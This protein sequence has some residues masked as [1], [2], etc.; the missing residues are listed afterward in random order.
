M[1]NDVFKFLKL[2]SDKSFHEERFMEGDVIVGG[3]LSYA[4]FADLPYY[5]HHDLVNGVTRM[6]AFYSEKNLDILTSNDLFPETAKIFFK[7]VLL[8][9]RYKNAEIGYFEDI[10]D[11]KLMAQF[12]AFTIF[13]KDVNVIIFRGTDPH[14]I[15][16]KED[17]DML[18]KSS[19]PSQVFAKKYLYK[20]SE[21]SNK[22]IVLIGHSKGGNLAYYAYLKAS[23]KIQKQV[24]KVYNLDGP[25][26]EIKLNDLTLLHKDK[27]VKMVPF[28]SIFGLMLDTTE[29]Y[30]IIKSSKKNILSHDLYTWEFSSESRFR[31]ILRMKKLVNKS[32]AMKHTINI[33]C[34]KYDKKDLKAVADFVYAVATANEK[35][36]TEAVKNELIEKRKVYLDKIGSYDKKKKEEVTKISKDLVKTYFYIRLH[37]RDFNIKNINDNDVLVEEGSYE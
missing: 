33:I 21:L 7:D 23:K 18:F 17:L 14:I 12:F 6:H 31:S 37:L 8:S 1:A 29:N 4:N 24:E 13:L 20:I 36:T 10:L 2:Y 16:W 19:I 25:G 22:P 34:R 3:I 9:K 15:G 5:K 32:I 27:L 26:F 11:E 35:K 30:E 28:N